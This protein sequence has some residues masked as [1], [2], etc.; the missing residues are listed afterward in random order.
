MQSEIQSLLSASEYRYDFWQKFINHFS[1]HYIAELGVYKGKFAEFTLKNCP[2]IQ[3]YI[4]ID[5]WRNLDN[6]NKPANKDD[7]KFEAYYQETLGK[8]EFAADKRI[9]LR[10]KTTEVID[11]IEDGSL[12]MVYIDGDHTLK[13]IAIDLISL[14]PKVKANGF[15]T[16]DDFSPT[17][18]QHEKRFEPTLVFP[19]AVYFA[20]AMRTRI[21]ALPYNQFVIT[22]ECQGFEFVDLTKGDYPDT[23]LLVHL[24]DVYRLKKSFKSWLARKLGGLFR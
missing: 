5:P 13:G 19:F 1:C 11:Q 24:N 15:V 6:W 9:V 2:E 14:W 16:G 21:F 18:W 3:Q 4:M 7:K 10:G 20:E 12:D 8:T 22:K 17:I 23:S